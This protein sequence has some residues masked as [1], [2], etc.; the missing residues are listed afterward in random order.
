MA[1]KGHRLL[2]GLAFITASGRAKWDSFAHSIRL[3]SN[4]EDLLSE[5]FC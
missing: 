5:H 2:L 3:Y 4:R 1:T